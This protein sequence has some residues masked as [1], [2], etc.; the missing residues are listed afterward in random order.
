MSACQVH[1]IDLTTAQ[2]LVRYVVNQLEQEGLV[3]TKQVTA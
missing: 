3:L 1:G 2:M